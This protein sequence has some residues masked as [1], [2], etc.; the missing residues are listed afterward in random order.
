[1]V[2]VQRNVQTSSEELNGSRTEL[3]KLEERIV[4]A[5]GEIK[6][7]EE[8]LKASRTQQRT[9]EQRFASL[10]G[11]VRTSEEQ[12]KLSQAEV[13]QLEEK[14]RIST[15]EISTMQTQ[16]CGFRERL[17]EMEVGIRR[18]MGTQQASDSVLRCP[19]SKKGR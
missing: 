1:L 15:Q 4:A 5:R 14:K 3:R 13:R 10:Q 9:L 2:N 7:S 18:L 16:M 17:S 11:E 19:L 8:Q 6:T 12:L